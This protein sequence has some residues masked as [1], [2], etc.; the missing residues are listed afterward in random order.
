MGGHLDLAFADGHADRTV[1]LIGHQRHA[2]DGG[3]H[4]VEIE[5]DLVI[6]V[7]RHDHF[8]IRKIAGKLAA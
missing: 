4:V 2:A 6:V 7:L 8:V 5:D 1:A 3:T